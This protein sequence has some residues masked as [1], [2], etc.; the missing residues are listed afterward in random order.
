MSIAKELVNNCNSC[1]NTSRQFCYQC[2]D[3]S[4]FVPRAAIQGVAS[5]EKTTNE[6]GGKQSKLEYAFH[7]I[8]A[9][10]MFALAKVMYE[11]AQNYEVDNWRKISVD[12]HINHAQSHIWAHKAGDKQDF[13]LSH[14]FTRCMM[15]LAVELQDE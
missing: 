10:A 12:E 7:L 15:A 8:D 13:H 5:E 9:K 11:G 6:Q 1:K 2:I 3:S 4:N 14:A